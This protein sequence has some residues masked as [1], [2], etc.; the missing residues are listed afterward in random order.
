MTQTALYS[1]TRAERAEQVAAL[2]SQGLLQRQIAD[3]IGISR[4]YVAELLID[5]D[6]SKIAKRRLD[7]RGV[8]RVCGSATTGTAGRSK[9]P[10]ICLGCYRL[11]TAAKHGTRSKYQGGC[12]CEPCRRANRELGRSLKG[13]EPPSHSASGYRN[14]GC[15]CQTCRDA[16]LVYQRSKAYEHQRAYRRQRAK[17]K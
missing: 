12:S 14:Y 10:T 7:N 17:A 2:R 15:R 13:Q 16:H 4:P 6:G 5:P 3:Q 8:C 11:E 1:V 9:A